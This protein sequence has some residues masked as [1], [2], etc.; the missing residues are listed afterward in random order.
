[1]FYLY[2]E[3]KLYSK[4]CTDGSD[5]IETTQEL[6]FE[7]GDILHSVSVTIIND[8]VY[9]GLEEFTAELTTADSGVDIF[10][11]RISDDD[12]NLIQTHM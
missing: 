7:P 1:M 10:Q 3:R 9:E 8:N 11:A 2:Y 12:G 5:Y 6:T 4:H